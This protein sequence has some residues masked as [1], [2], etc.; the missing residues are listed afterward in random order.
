[1]SNIIIHIAG[2]QG[3]GKTTMGSKLLK[4]YKDKIYVKDLDE[5]SSENKYSNNYQKF[6]DEFI[7]SH[8]DKPL[9]FVGLDAELCLGS[10]EDSDVVYDLHATHKFYIMTSKDVLK[11]RFFRQI[12]KLSDR[13]EWFFDQYLKNPDFIQNK[14]FR[15]VDLNAWIVN[16]EKCDKL[17]IS[18]K[19][20][21]LDYD[22][23]YKNVC[24]KINININ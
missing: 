15:F 5:L 3:S 13:R 8:K 16:N 18:R 4:K 14:L 19:Y 2:A 20:E 6:I 24:K 21:F 7:E 1:M 23:L 9:I 12:E 22:S 17:Y 10:M 11:Q